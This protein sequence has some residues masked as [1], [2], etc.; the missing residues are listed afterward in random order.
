VSRDNKLMSEITILIGGFGSGKTECALRLALD[1][2][3]V[4][5]KTSLVDLD[6]V[7][8]MFRS[9]VQESI[10]QDAGVY[11]ITS[12]ST[13]MKLGVPVVSAEVNAAFQGRYEFV[14]FD[15]GGDKIGATALGQ[16][17][18]QLN[19]VRAQTNVL[20]VVNVRRPS[21]DTPSGVL[22]ALRRIESAAR[23]RVDGFVNNTNLAMET[24]ADMLMEGDAILRDVYT[25]TGVPIRYI[26]GMT[27]VLED[28]DR[29]FAGTYLG[30]RLTLSPMMRPDWLDHIKKGS[31]LI[32]KGES[33]MVDFKIDQERCKGCGLCVNACPK[34]LLSLATDTMN[35]KGYHPVNITRV[36]ECV[37]CKACALTCPDSC[38]EIWK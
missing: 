22:S 12:E 30:E 1:G 10:L 5:R 38:I 24:T 23:L 16:Y 21:F 9:T 19:E 6:I 34:K 36:A 13:R 29:R 32:R 17:H 37:A 18:A 15:V 7:N 28:L 11:L 20:F 33:E 3:K 25:Q 31:T 27:H 4:G 14:V 8:P 2:A 35:S 26:S